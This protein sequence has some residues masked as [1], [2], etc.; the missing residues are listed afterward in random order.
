[1]SLHV[2]RIRPDRHAAYLAQLDLFAASSSTELR[3]IAR[4]CTV[5][6]R[7]SGATLAREGET[8][9]EFLVIKSGAA[10]ATRGGLPDVVL[11]AG[12]SFGDADILA[13]RESSAGLVALTDVELIVM[14]TAEFS[15]LLDAAP[16]FRR[17]VIKRLAGD[18]RAS[19]VAGS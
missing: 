8:S 19:S 13:K 14:S 15:G 5:V 12:D 10:L 4:S 3:T 9:R 17:R 7:R 6:T 11:C 2:R 16:S 18:A 1:M